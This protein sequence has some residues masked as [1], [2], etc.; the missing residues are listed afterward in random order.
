MTHVTRRG[1]MAAGGLGV[2]AVGGLTLPLGQSASAKD[3][4]STSAKPARF[5]RR[6]PVPEA[7]TPTVLS[8]EFGEY[9][10][11][12]ITE[13]AAAAQVLDAGAPKTTV[14]G[15]AAGDGGPSVPGPLIKVDQNT[16]VRLR[17]RNELPPTHPTFGY[18]VA[19]SVH[20]H[21]S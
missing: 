4:I 15:Y 3:W 20:L 16:R 14:F 11:Y 8:D 10:L 2:V 6:L 12:E 7:M 1:L 17:V 9:H 18:P 5:A 19:T 13:R 21:G